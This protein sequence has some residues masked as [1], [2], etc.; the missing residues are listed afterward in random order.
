MPATLGPDRSSSMTSKS[1]LQR[2]S[3]R[4]RQSLELPVILEATA[5]EIQQ[6]LQCDRVMIYQFQPDGSGQVVAEQLGK[7]APLPSLHHLFF[8]ADDIPESARHL[9]LAA[10]VR[11]VVDVASRR[12]GQSRVYHPDS[13]EAL[14]EDW[15]FRPLDPC[16]A[17]YLTAMG[18]ASS[19][20][21][22]IIHQEAT[23]GLLVAHHATTLSVDDRARDN[24]QMVV[25]QMSIAISQSIL[26]AQA[27]ET[28][29]KEATINRISEQ[30]ASMEA[31]DLDAALRETV[32]VLR[33]SGG[34]LYLETPE[35]P[36]LYLQGHQPSHHPLSP[37]P[38]LEKASAIDRYFSD[39]SCSDQSLQYWAM[40]DLY[41]VPALRNVQ[42][43]F[44]DNAIAG[45]LII[46]IVSQQKRLGYLTLFRD[47]VQTETLWAGE[48][49]PDARQS[50]PR[51][52]FQI[53]K[54][55]CDHQV[56]PWTPHDLNLAQAIADQFSTAIAQTYLH[57]EVQAL[58]LNLKHLNA[59]LELQVEAR[60][61][62]LQQA[63]L[64]Q[65]LLFQ[66]VAKIRQSLDLE[67]IFKITT[68]EV[69]Q[70][71]G[72]D[73]VGIYQFDL[74]SQFN[75][76]EIIAEDVL[77]NFTSALSVK[78]HDH[79]F[80]DRYANLYSQ[81]RV[82]AMP[83]I[84]Q[85][86]LSDCY[87]AVLEQ[88]E[89]KASLVAPIL[90]GEKL[91]GLFCIHQCDRPR[92]WQPTEMQFVSQVA[93]QV[94]IALEQANLLSRTQ[95]QATAM[96]QVVEEL[97]NTQMQLVQQEKMSSLGQL[98]A[99]IAHE[100]N[101]PVNFIHGNLSYINQYIDEMMS[102]VECYQAEIPNPSLSLQTKLA[103][104]EW[105]YL[106]EDLPKIMSSM[107]VGTDRIREIV[108]SLRNFSRLDQATFKAVNI[109]EGIDS[110]LLIIQHRLNATSDRPE[111]KIIKDYGDLP[112]VE[113]YAGSLNQ[114]FM[115]IVSNAI[116]AIEERWSQ[117][118]ST[119][120]LTYMNDIRL[121]TDRYS[122]PQGV[123][124]VRICIQDHGSGISQDKL[125]KIFDPFYTT[126][127]VGKG[128]GL[129]L[130]ISHQIITEHH[131]GELSCTSRLNS[132]STFVIDIPVIHPVKIPG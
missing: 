103:D 55:S 80:G 61:A 62:D 74:A 12:I 27:R 112:L 57:R 18:V 69:R 19:L 111:I 36:L 67:R 122:N 71:L 28:A 11:N 2:I 105:D 49:D 52:S 87:R 84:D 15:I 76:G 45:L 127:A 44:Q 86:G 110:T 130:S 56:L 25:D 17:E 114:V 88:F 1:L 32:A 48:F 59:N 63:N 77:P 125:Q 33:A 30:L 109:H 4:I 47:R 100:I 10:G 78:V 90:R 101:N 79:C 95:S 124:R 6:F 3:L 83:D 60:T 72:A 75:D 50:Y 26:L 132:G 43:L 131:Q 24:I 64:Q 107:R 38:I 126:K 73:R 97:Q 16:H 118:D 37:I 8:P 93:S 31:I 54:Q 39:Q 14:E 68:R 89:I 5:S 106:C 98:V 35:E 121:T 21:V 42:P 22:P 102:M 81:G 65:D 40:D 29:K 117:L 96:A 92:D 13:G 7:D 34:R 123:D 66:V 128:T 51:Q 99:G 104:I 53:W 85:A 46:P 20:V 113:C 58:N 94:S 120:R 119:A 115:N 82:H 9:F 70:I 23:W 41:Q 129:G 108:L 91:W 116:D